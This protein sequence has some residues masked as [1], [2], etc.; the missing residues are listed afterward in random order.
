MEKGKIIKIIS[1]QYL[2][3]SKG[4]KISCI[5]MGKLRK[6]DV[7]VVGDE[8]YFESFT[9]QHG[10]QKILPRKN[11]LIR[12]AI[13]NIDQAIIVISAKEPDASLTLIDRMIFQVVYQGIEPILCFTKMDLITED[14]PVLSY[15]NMYRESGYSVFVSDKDH[16]CQ[17]LC[18]C[19]SNKVSVLCGQSGAGKSSLLNKIDE[20][21]QLQTQE[22]SKALGRGKH[23]TRHCELHEVCGGWV[24]DTPG[25]S[26]LDF[27]YMKIDVLQDKIHEFQ[28]Y[29]GKCKFRNCIHVNEPHCA[30]KEAYQN[31]KIRSSCYENYLDVLEKFIMK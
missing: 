5:A 28:P 10:I 19:F 21:F 3:L 27:S 7:P 14:D 20:S 4:K 29:L 6:Q 13:A 26:S 24:A 30:I 15:I 17:N 18:D 23:T 12:P 25:F 8:V 16:V 2:V 31:K 22:I 1:N 11:K 9:S